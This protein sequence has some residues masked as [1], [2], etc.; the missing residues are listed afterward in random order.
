MPPLPQVSPFQR[1]VNK[2]K[3][4]EKCELCHGR[5]NVVFARGKLPC[6]LLFIGEAPG[7]SEDMLGKPFIGPA[8][9]L[10]DDIIL[11]VVPQELRVAFTNLVSCIPLEN[12]GEEKGNKLG[13]PPKA[14]IAA[15]APRLREMVTMAKPRA[16][17]CV[18]KLASEY[19]LK[20]DFKVPL[21]DIVH[22]AAILRAP[23][24]QRGLMAQRCA[25]VLR[26]GVEAHVS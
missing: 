10:I 5:K 9:H 20:M 25:V 4:C 24:A 3:S 11:Q 26:D 17:V 16:I 23:L 15:C 1:H 2:W 7:K 22:P 13:Q 14:A 21:I 12:E 18:G 8:G 6:D 19:V